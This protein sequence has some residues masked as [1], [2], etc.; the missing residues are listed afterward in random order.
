M[1]ADIGR[2]VHELANPADAMFDA[3]TEDPEALTKAAPEAPPL[4]P[5]NGHEP[6]DEP[7]RHLSSHSDLRT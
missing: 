4:S 2:P 1:L 6:G 3:L 7:L 5:E